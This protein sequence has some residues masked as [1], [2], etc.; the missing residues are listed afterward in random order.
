MSL[1]TVLHNRI[2]ELEGKILTLNEVHHLCDVF[3][4]KHSTAERILRPSTS[5]NVEPVLNKKNYIIGYKLK[6]ENIK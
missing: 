1:K 5:P 6:Q 2:T 4:Y 3:N